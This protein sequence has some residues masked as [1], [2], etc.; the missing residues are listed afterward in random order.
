MDNLKNYT[1]A[2]MLAIIVVLSSLMTCNSHKT[3]KEQGTSR[4]TTKVTH[5]TT[6]AKDTMYVFKAQ[7]FPKWDTIKT[8]DS[9]KWNVDLC[10][11]ERTYRDSLPDS[12]VTIFTDIKTIG[13]LKSSQIKYKLK[14][15]LRIE[16]TIRT[17]STYIKDSTHTNRWELIG[18]GGVGGNASKFNLTAG[19]AI[20]Y[21]RV[22]Y[23]YEYNFADKTHNAKV[24]L[25]LYK[26][27]K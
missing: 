15:P 6:Y 19:A 10:K 20:R 27:R 9:S 17:D 2:I 12:N 21:N 5:D 18:I 24:G 4:V 3:I 13:I 22:Y 23:G 11:S 26:S 16:T 8:I 1:I 14:V 7:Y 25:V